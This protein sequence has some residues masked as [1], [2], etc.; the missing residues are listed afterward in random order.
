M[1]T[2]TSGKRSSCSHGE[3][4]NTLHTAKYLNEAVLFLVENC[5]KII[6]DVLSDFDILS[7]YQSRIS[8]VERH[9]LWHI[10]GFF[11]GGEDYSMMILSTFDDVK[12]NHSLSP[13]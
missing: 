11:L 8:H 10:S 6:F 7:V 1:P 3:S 4:K 13:S 2:K 12:N 5:Y 9:Q